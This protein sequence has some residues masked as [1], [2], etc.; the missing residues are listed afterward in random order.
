MYG[1]VRASSTALVPPVNMT[2]SMDDLPPPPPP[3]D[4]NTICLSHVSDEPVPIP[5]EKK[6]ELFSSKTKEE[7]P[8]NKNKKDTTSSMD[9][10]NIDLSQVP[11]YTPITPHTPIWK[12]D[13]IEK[14]NKEKIQEYLESLRKQK[15]EAEKW[16]GVPE[17]KRKLVLEKEKQKVQ[18]V[19]EKQK[20]AEAAEAEKKR[21]TKEAEEKRKEMLRQQEE[22]RRQMEQ[23]LQ[24]AP[25]WKREI[26]M[27]RG[28]AIRNWGDEREEINKE[29][30]H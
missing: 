24:D 9:I 6:I 30:Q 14:K 3:A 16:K 10:N 19:E 26:M 29:G 20:E 22:E 12:K 18:T 5:V 27:K 7:Q 2:D 8:R 11:G 21:Q 23:E 25:A 28:G 15:E 17:W 13:V 4:F 1:C